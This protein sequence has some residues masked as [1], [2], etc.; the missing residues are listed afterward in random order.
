MVRYTVWDSEQ[1]YALCIECFGY[2]RPGK[3]I[4]HEGKR[5]KVLRVED[6]VYNGKQ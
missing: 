4:E 6:K 1:N 3:Y 2:Y 5:Y